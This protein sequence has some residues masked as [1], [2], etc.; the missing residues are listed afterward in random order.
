[1]SAIA[2]ARLERLTDERSRTEQNIEEV[3]KTAEKENERDLNEFETDQVEKWRTRIVDL[4]V[5]IN[6]LADDLER[7]NDTR[8]VS[9]LLRIVEPEPVVDGNGA[10]E[11]P[12]VYRT[13]AAFAR[14]E[15]IARF[16]MI[17]NAAGGDKAKMEA[18]DRLERAL[19]NTLSSDVAGLLPPQHLAEI[20][21]L[22]NNARPVVATSRRVDLARGKMT[23][24]K[25]SGRPAVI[26]QNTEKTQAGSIKMEFTLEDVTAETYLGGGNISW[27]TINWSTPDA[28]QL[29][30]ELA[31]EAYAQQTETAACGVLEA[32]ASG[33]VS[34][35]LG[36]AGTESL[37]DWSAAAIGAVG[38]VYSTTGG[39]AR[40]NT[41]YLA[42]DQFFV[43]AGLSTDAVLQMSAVGNLDIGAMTGTFRGLRVVGSY[44]FAAGSRIIGDSAAFLCGETPGAPVEMRAVEPSIGGMDVGVIGAFKAKVFDDDRFLFLS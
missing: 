10:G 4:D 21:D 7:E 16:P 5:E 2:R 29:W 22:I 20:M 14:D 36:T 17:A 26:K 39:R 1:M 23:Y 12:V 43:L 40:T 31:A 41:L 11:G 9:K 33:T 13:F 27:Q 28:L 35:A 38:S 24:P 15:L 30:F 3:R 25:I 18:V 6:V 8:D 32:A 44:G 42:A 37:A 34:P 19:Q